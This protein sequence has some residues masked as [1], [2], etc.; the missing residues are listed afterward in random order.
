LLEHGH[1]LGRNA[2]VVQRSF[3][4]LVVNSVA[5]TNKQSG[6]HLRPPPSKGA[7]CF[8]TMMGQPRKQGYSGIKRLTRR[9]IGW[10]TIRR[11]LP[12]TL[13][14][15]R[16][17]DALVVRTAAQRL[18]L[19]IL[20]FSLDAFWCDTW[21]TAVHR[22]LRHFAGPCRVTVWPHIEAAVIVVTGSATSMAKV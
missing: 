17:N 16:R 12:T 15:R 21:K 5:S 22:P 7:P 4:G 18:Y 13:V 10:P 3:T 14:T 6:M 1:L 8:C 2:C 11:R 9:C 20:E 19:G